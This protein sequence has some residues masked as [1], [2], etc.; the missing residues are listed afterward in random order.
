MTREEI[1]ETYGDDEEILFAD[2]LDGAIVGID[3]NLRVVYDIDTIIEILIERDKM[4][5]EE[6]VEFAEFNIFGAYV[7]EKTPIYMYT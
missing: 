2:G 6:A 4:T 1:L 3:Y 7:G 5:D